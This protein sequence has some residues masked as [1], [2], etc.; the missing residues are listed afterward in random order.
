MASNPDVFVPAE[1]FCASFKFVSY[2]ACRPGFITVVAGP[3]DTLSGTL[4]YGTPAATSGQTAVPPH[5]T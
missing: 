3:T 1:M 4:S 2:D 5:L